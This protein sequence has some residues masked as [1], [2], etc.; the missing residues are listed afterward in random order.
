MIDDV[1]STGGALGLCLPNTIQLT[2]ASHVELVSNGA[3]QDHVV[4]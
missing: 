4:L 2:C 3:E 1:L